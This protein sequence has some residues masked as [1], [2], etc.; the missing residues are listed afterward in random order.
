MAVRITISKS[1]NG[2]GGLS[3]GGKRSSVGGDSAS[4]KLY[5]YQ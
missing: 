4:T 3:R 5:R 1:F 2:G